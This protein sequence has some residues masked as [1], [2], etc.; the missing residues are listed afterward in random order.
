VSKYW[1][2]QGYQVNDKT[3]WLDMDSVEKVATE[4]KP[5]MLVCGTSA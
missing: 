5:D 1:Q 2:S 3:G 4:F